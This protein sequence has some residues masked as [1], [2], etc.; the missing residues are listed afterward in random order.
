MAYLASDKI[1]VFPSI[2][3]DT[4]TDADAELMNEGN[5]SNIVRSLCR[6]RKSYVFSKNWTSNFELVIYGFYF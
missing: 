2:G 6:E 3:R 5:I 4:P 1:K